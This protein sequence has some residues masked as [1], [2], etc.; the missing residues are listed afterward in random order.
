MTTGASK[1]KGILVLKSMMVIVIRSSLDNLLF[2][3]MMVMVITCNK[4]LFQSMMVMVMVIILRQPLVPKH[5]ISLQ[6][7][8]QVDSMIVF[9]RRAS[10]I[11]SFVDQVGK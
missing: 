3:S 2:K 9:P 11:L 8:A 10:T 5:G 4:L 6:E 1:E 7:E